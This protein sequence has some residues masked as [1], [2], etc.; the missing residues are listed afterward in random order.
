MW[1]I[2]LNNQLHYFYDDYKSHP[3]KR[4]YSPNMVVDIALFCEVMTSFKKL[5]I[6]HVDQFC[7]TIYWS[8]AI[9]SCT[10]ESKKVCQRGTKQHTKRS[11]L[12]THLSG[13]KTK[14]TNSWN[15][16]KF[17][18]SPVFQRQE[19]K[20]SIFVWDAQTDV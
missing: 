14:K 4:L 7:G 3:Y 11:H 19:W 5:I 13:E 1:P 12:K 10:R 18:I 6:K 20:L 2:D 16:S 15:E 8:K 17:L 9:K